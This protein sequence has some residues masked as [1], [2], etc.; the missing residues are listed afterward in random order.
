[1][2]ILPRASSAYGQDGQGRNNFSAG[3]GMVMVWVDPIKGWVGKYLVTQD[4]Y[5]KIMG[6]NPSQYKGPRHP[7]EMVNWYEAVDYCKKLTDQDRASGVL[8]VGC[9]YNLPTDAQFDV[10]V[11]D[12]AGVDDATQLQNQQRPN[13]TADVGTGKA[14]QYGLYDTRG[15]IWQWTLDDFKRSMNSGLEMAKKYY[16][17]AGGS[18]KI[19]RGGMVPHLSIVTPLAYHYGTRP[20][21]HFYINGFRVVAVPAQ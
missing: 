1:L 12:A 4:E 20:G 14:N 13:L 19:L 8:P 6:T 7:V 2:F 21:L 10:F 5:E 9:Q 17:F 16:Y 11:G 18:G 15:L 3:N